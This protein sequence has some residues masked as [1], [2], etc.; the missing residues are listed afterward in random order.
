MINNS[1]QLIDN[2]CDDYF[3]IYKVRRQISCIIN[4]LSIDNND[5]KNIM[6]LCYKKTNI[7]LANYIIENN[8][9]DDFDISIK[10]KS[11]F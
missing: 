7:L 11:K 9:S 6:E 2:D 5:Y 8:D 10:I 1:I 3:K 4:Q